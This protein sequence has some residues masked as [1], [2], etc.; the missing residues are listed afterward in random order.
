MSISDD[1]CAVYQ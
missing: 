1:V